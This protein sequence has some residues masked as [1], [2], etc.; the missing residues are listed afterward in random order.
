[1]GCFP[2]GEASKNVQ[3]GV[4]RRFAVCHKAFLL[5][6]DLSPLSIVGGKRW[7]FYLY[8]VVKVNFWKIIAFNGMIRTFLNMV[9]VHIESQRHPLLCLFGILFSCQC[10]FNSRSFK[11]LYKIFYCIF[12]TIPYGSLSYIFSEAS[13]LHLMRGCLLIFCFSKVYSK[14]WAVYRKRDIQRWQELLVLIF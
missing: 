3:T 8:A 9:A 5:I 11:D 4:S 2:T 6:C 13:K 7:N 1:M 14:D 12:A 10:P